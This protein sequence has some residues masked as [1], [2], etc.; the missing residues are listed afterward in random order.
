LRFCVKTKKRNSIEQRISRKAFNFAVNLLDNH[1]KYPSAKNSLYNSSQI[2]QCLIQLSLT[3][4]YAESGL[5]NLQIKV[6][7]NKTHIPTGRTFR[8]RTQRLTEKQIRNALTNANDQM[9]HTLKSHGILKRKA[10]V[11]IDYTTQP[12][13]G[14]KN[15]KNIIGGKQDRESKLG[16]HLR[17]HRPSRGWATIH[18]LHH[19]N[20]PIQRKSRH[21]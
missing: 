13:Y 2:N 21:C 8:A 11:A 12:F 5:A 7:T 9:L 17:Q 6:A 16:I 1:L 4:S 20:N 3:Q 18:N 10:T 15:A 14:N 19:H